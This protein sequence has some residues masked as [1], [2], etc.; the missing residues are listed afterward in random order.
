MTAFLFDFLQQINGIGLKLCDVGIGVQ[1]VDAARGVPR[2]ARRQ[3]T[4]FQHDNICPAEFGEVI[5]HRR[6]NDPAPDDN[7]AILRFHERL[8]QAVLKDRARDS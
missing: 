1:R 8:P 3:H 2:G 4:A 7:N 6:A 5:K